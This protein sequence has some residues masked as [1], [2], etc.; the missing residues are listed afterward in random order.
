MMDYRV[1]SRLQRKTMIESE[2]SQVHLQVKL[3]PKIAF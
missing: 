1:I 3:V 2:A